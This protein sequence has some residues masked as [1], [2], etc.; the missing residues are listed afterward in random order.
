MAVSTTPRRSLDEQDGPLT[1]KEVAAL[2]RVDDETV[3]TW[4]RLGKLRGRRLGSGSGGSPW[5]I[6]RSE[7]E[8]LDLEV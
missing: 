2:L 7:L 4:L 5:R 6:P 3:R 1:V 8:K